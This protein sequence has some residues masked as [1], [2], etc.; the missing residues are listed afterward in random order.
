[1]NTNDKFGQKRDPKDVKT[2]PQDEFITQNSNNLSQ[3]ASE[4]PVHPG[5]AVPDDLDDREIDEE[6]L[7][8]KNRPV[9]KVDKEENEAKT[10]Q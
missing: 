5:A 4:T 7:E 3:T 9:E 1:M 10:G 8:A 2:Q 6:G